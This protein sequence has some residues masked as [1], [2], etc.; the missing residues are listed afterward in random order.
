MV[1]VGR[2]PFLLTDE[3]DRSSGGGIEADARGTDGARAREQ[4]SEQLLCAYV[5]C[6]LPEHTARLRELVAIPTV[7]LFRPGICR[8]GV[9]GGR[10]L[11]VHFVGS[12]RQRALCTLLVT[13]LVRCCARCGTGHNASAT[14]CRSDHAQER[15]CAAIHLTPPP[16]PST[17]HLTPQPDPLNLNAKRAEARRGFKGRSERAFVCRH[18]PNPST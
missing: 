6:R 9:P 11:G 10:G 3:G 5:A 16:N 17:D 1:A 14:M 15:S 13:R 7:R 4:N 2:Q 18:T 12:S 8:S